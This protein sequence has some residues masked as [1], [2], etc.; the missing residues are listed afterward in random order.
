METLSLLLAGFAV[1]LTPTNIW[2]GL[3]GSFAGTVI[4]ALPGLGP[5]NGIALL[6]PLVFALGLPPD[7]ALILLVCIY[8]GAMY[9]GRVS[10]ILLNIPGDEPAIMTTLDGYPMARQG[11]GE[12]ALAI[13]AISSFVGALLATVALMFLAPP[14][15][16]F[17][18][19][20]GPAEYFVL[21]V[22]AFSAITSV[23]GNNP[24]K[25]FIGAVIGLMFA[26]VGL[27][28]GSGVPRYTFGMLELY[29]GVDFI[30][31]LVG[32]FAVSE[33]LTFVDHHFDG[34]T[35]P[36]VMVG[37]VTT[38]IKEVAGTGW[39]MLR[40]SVVG[41]IGGVLPG[42]GAS[43]GA[44][45]AYSL[46]QRVSDKNGTFGKGDKRGVAAPESGNN[47]GAMAGLIPM[48]AL[49]I[50]ASAT[51]ALLLAMLVALGVTPGPLL[52]D[53]EPQLVWGL[54]AALF[55]ANVALLIMNLPMV[56][57]FVR[58]L[59]IPSWILMP[60]VTMVGFVGIFSISHSSF[61][62]LTMIF[63]GVLG[64]GCRKLDISLVPI[65]LGLVLGQP[66]EINLRRAL[67]LSN[68]D[69]T[70][71]VGSPLA[72][73]L[74]IMAALGLIVPLLLRKRGPSAAIRQQRM[75]DA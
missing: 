43:L 59:S 39:T 4:G 18:V 53:Q 12:A 67:T 8:Q 44:F 54:V 57:V 28:P 58:L 42:A 2:I 30:V 16:D 72:V 15:A 68:G 27:D 33:L 5:A 29:E 32:L 25:T 9:G 56:G 46:E 17:A 63:F 1:A 13:G 61:D 74:W 71:L 34:K 21:Y 55:L 24:F 49:G 11:K 52:F 14:L 3:M 51:T 26:S 73:G 40:G 69:W 62:I 66:M 75:D 7:T 41:F 60:M 37:K 45:L 23:T 31:A 48:L 36:R 50:P 65:T 6:L 64:Y 22:L 10:S 47:A 38:A 19:R 70:V 20:F 35:P